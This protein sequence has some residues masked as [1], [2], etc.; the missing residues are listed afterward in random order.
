[1]LNKIIGL[2]LLN[3]RIMDGLQGDALSR[4]EDLAQNLTEMVQLSTTITQKEA[5][6]THY[7]ETLEAEEQKKAKGE[8]TIIPPELLDKWQREVKNLE[9]T[10]SQLY[11]ERNKTIEKA[12]GKLLQQAFKYEVEQVAQET[13]C[14]D[15][16]TAASHIQQEVTTEIQDNGRLKIHFKKDGVDW[17]DSTTGQPLTLKTRMKLMKRDKPYLFNDNQGNQT[18]T[19]KVARVRKNSFGKVVNI[20]TPNFTYPDK[21]LTATQKAALERQQMLERT[22]RS[23]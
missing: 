8:A 7:K 22:G 20:N 17:L 16:E 23:M 21:T 9:K 13:G 12:E 15:V 5:T 1:M 18:E 10:L 6:L 11:G 3:S 4:Q 2:K 19:Q 14:F